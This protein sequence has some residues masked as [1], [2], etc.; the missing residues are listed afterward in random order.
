MKCNVSLFVS[1]LLAPSISVHSVALT[2]AGLMHWVGAGAG[3]GKA[4]RRRIS[5]YITS[6]QLVASGWGRNWG[7]VVVGGGECEW[8]QWQW[9][10]CC[11]HAFVIGLI[12]APHRV[13]NTKQSDNNMRGM[14]HQQQ[15]QRG[16]HLH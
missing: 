16:Q 5:A 14:Q 15:Q 12:G 1:L 9:Y 6:V 11:C 3:A 4:E 10:L 13:A 2:R 8:G 7:T